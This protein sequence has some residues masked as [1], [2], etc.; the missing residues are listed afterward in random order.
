VKINQSDIARESDEALRRFLDDLRRQC[1]EHRWGPGSFAW[2]LGEAV[3]AA[4]QERQQHAHVLLDGLD[5]A[6]EGES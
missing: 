6:D 4:L 1:I 3:H 5:L 2:V